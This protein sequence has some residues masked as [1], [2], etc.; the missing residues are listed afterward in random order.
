VTDG[1][2]RISPLGDSAITV[3]FAD[4]LDQ[5]ARG[6][7]LA[8]KADLGRRPLPGTVEVVAA[9]TTLTVHYDP[10]EIDFAV[11]KGAL[12][13]RL[14]SEPAAPTVQDGAIKEIRVRYQGPDLE[15]VAHQTGLSPGEVIDRHAG[16]T[17]QVLLL[18][19]VP[20]FA[21]LGEL[22]PA[23]R[24][25]RRETPRERVPAGSVA[26]AGAQTGIYPAETPGGWHLI[27]RTAARLFDPGRDPPALLAVGDQ[28]RFVPERS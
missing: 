17:Y 24:L 10:L 12:V 22:D 2:P 23:L 21:Y 20:G 19:F 4:Q 3:T 14:P 26:I 18:G 16:R 15:Y 11:L 13:G 7:V 8:L 6:L 1:L 28:V 27:G 9:T 25:P 5:R